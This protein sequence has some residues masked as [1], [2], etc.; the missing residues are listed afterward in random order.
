MCRSSLSHSKV[1]PTQSSM[2]GKPIEAHMHAKELRPTRSGETI[3]RE[4]EREREEEWSSSEQVGE[5]RGG[6]S[7]LVQFLA[8]VWEGV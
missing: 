6:A 3:E 2:L 5:G 8:F 7:S 4:R 1:N